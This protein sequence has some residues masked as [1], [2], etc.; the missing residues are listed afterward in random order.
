MW[1]DVASNQVQVAIGS[2]QAFNTVA[3]KGLVRPI[4]ATGRFRSPRLPDVPTL[5]E[6]GMKDV[7]VTL[8]GWLPMIAPAG[9]PE[10]ILARLAEV[11]VEWG[12]TPRAAQLRETFAIPNRPTPLEESRRRYRD[13]SVVWIDL[14]KQLGITLD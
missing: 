1:V 4:G 2:F 14:A 3:S 7:L 8:D 6:A 11:A 9:T 12:E 10:P 5:T 13:E